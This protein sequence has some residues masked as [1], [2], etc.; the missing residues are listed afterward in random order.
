ML[1]FRTKNSRRAWHVIPAQEVNSTT[2]RISS[3]VV[4]I[5]QARLFIYGSYRSTTIKM[6]LII[7]KIIITVYIHVKIIIFTARG[8]PGEPAQA[9]TN[10]RDTHK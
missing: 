3:I 9:S 2:R 10:I 4:R 7:K 8:M 5:T 1:Q 6:L